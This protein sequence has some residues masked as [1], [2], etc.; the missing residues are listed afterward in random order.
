M[1]RSCGEGTVVADTFI[2]QSLLDSGRLL[3]L[4]LMSS[5]DGSHTGLFILCFCSL[6]SVIKEIK[7]Q[8]LE[9]FQSSDQSRNRS[10]GQKFFFQSMSR[11]TKSIEIKISYLNAE[12]R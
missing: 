7:S 3:L 12:H 9:L 1:T 2:F 6:S 11:C 10:N 8:K 4:T 5:G